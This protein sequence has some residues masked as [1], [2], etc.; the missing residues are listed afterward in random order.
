M[1]DILI[2]NVNLKLLRRQRDYLLKC[3]GEGVED[4]IDGIINLLDYILD[5]EE[6]WNIK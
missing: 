1:T 5:K 2:K 6:K 3:Y 4:K